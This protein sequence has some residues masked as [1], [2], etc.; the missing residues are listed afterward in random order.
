[1]VFTIIGKL[2]NLKKLKVTDVAANCAMNIEILNN[3]LG[4]QSQIEDLE[5]QFTHKASEKGCISAIKFHKYLKKLKRLKLTN[6]W[7]RD[8]TESL[9]DMASQRHL[10]TLD[11]Q[12]V[13]EVALPNFCEALSIFRRLQRLSLTGLNFSKINESIFIDYLKQAPNLS[14]LI[15][16]SVD[17][18]NQF[19]NILKAFRHSATLIEMRLINIPI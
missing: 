9:F 2:K 4:R 3:S 10:K 11:L 6:V 5:V 19:A 7:H 17:V 1:M 8:F 12:F 13:P 14:T 16:D 18:C 15:L